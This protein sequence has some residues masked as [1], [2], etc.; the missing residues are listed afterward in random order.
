MNGYTLLDAVGG[1]RAGYV[2]AAKQRRARSQSRFSGWAAA[3][4]CL[5]LVAAVLAVTGLH[6]KG[7]TAQEGT[8]S[9]VQE[10]RSLEF[11]GAYYEATDIPEALERCGLPTVLT[12]DLAGEH[13]SWLRSDGGAGYAPSAAETGIEL[14]TYAP[15]P[16]K[17]VYLLWDG[18]RLYAALLSNLWTTDN[19]STELATLYQVYGVSGAA[20]IASI[21]EVDWHRERTIGAPV[22]APGALAAFYELSD[23]L[24][25]YG[26]EDFQALVFDGIPEERQAQAHA[27]FAD[28]LRMLRIETTAGLRFYLEL[29]PAYGWMAA[30]GTLSYYRIDSQM[31]AWI[32]RNLG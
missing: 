22:S 25:C 17:G 18:G 13:V 14:M 9:P 1:I 27:E 23:Q 12:E 7:G 21:C 28:D 16:C 8:D 15:A 32:E 5:C 24:A 29:Y 6:G 2:E 11:N 26:N 30:D 31:Q 19:A 4:A 20:D 10:I 3:A